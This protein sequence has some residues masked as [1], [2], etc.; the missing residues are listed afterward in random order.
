MLL[1][2]ALFGAFTVGAALSR[3]QWLA[4]LLLVGSGFFLT[5][6]F[7]TLNSLVQEMAPDALRGPRALDLRPRLPRR[8]AG[9]QPAWPACSCAAPARPRVMAVYSA[10]AARGGR[11]CSL[12]ARLPR[13]AARCERQPGRLNRG[14]VAA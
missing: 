5:T 7:S 11:R 14:G 13:A 2:F 12:V 1:A 9:R 3:W 8:R 6:A 4:M 10:A